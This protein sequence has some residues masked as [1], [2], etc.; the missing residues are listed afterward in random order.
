MCSVVVK[1]VV[2]PTRLVIDYSQTINLYTKKDGFP[3]PLI[4]EIVNE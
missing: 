3:I 1:Q 2:I 4:E